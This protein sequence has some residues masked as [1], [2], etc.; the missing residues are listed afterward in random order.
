MNSNFDLNIENYT[1]SELEQIFELPSNYDENIIELQEKKLK[2]NILSNND[3]EIS[4]K[5]KTTAFINLAKQKL[6][7]TLAEA[8]TAINSGKAL[9]KT[10]KNVYNLDKTLQPVET[11]STS[12]KFII[13]KPET[14]YGKSMP[15]EYYEG[16]INPLDRRILRKYLNIDTRFRENYYSTQAS[17]IHIDLPIRLTQVVSMQLSSIELPG[18]FYAISN[19]FGNNFFTIS[20]STATV[21]IVVPNGNYSFGN[22]Q[23]YINNYLAALSDA[24]LNKLRLTIDIDNESGSGK[25]IFAIDS[26]SPSIFNFTL[27]FAGDINGNEDFNTPL[28]LKL[29]WLMGFREGKYINNSSYVSEG[30]I[31]LLGPKYLYVVVD[32]YTNN[33]NDGF[34]AAFNTSILNK[35]ILARISLQA[36]PFNFA[37]Q[38]NLLLITT[39]RQYFGPIDIQKLNIQLLDEYGR[40]INLNNMDYSLCLC[41]QTIYDL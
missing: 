11:I 36:I 13:N 27:D 24:Q 21:T 41:F 32:E 34:Y 3:L 28:P 19:I 5:M 4:V 37:S 31:D 30:M 6:L 14:P 1:K 23:D 26:L 15:S 12:G 25:S 17:N 8:K 7:D 16:V 2:Q 9:L 20:C 10:Y 18:T 29:G 40:V 33:T 22:F 39:P 38:N 35:N